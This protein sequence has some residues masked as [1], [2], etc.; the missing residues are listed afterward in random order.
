MTLNLEYVI[1]SLTKTRS[2]FLAMVTPPVIKKTE[3]HA[4]SLQVESNIL[5]RTS[6]L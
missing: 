4:L 5:E 1:A 3:S 2:C 6:L